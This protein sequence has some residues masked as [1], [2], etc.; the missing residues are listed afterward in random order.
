MNMSLYEALED[1]AVHMAT[2][3][4]GPGHEIIITVTDQAPSPAQ[5]ITSKPP[6]AA[7]TGQQVKAKAEILWYAIM[8]I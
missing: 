4:Q 1:S 6:I 3:R 5:A 2:L 8:C 7:C